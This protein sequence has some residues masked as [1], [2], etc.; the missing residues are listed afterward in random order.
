MESPS[1]PGQFIRLTKDQLLKAQNDVR[2]T[3]VQALGGFVL[4][5]GAGVGAYLTSRQVRVAREGQITERFTRAIDQ[6]GSE[7]LD[8]R[9]GG[10][11]ALERIARGSKD[12]HGP[13]IE[14]LTTYLREHSPWP[15]SRPGQY[16]AMASIEDIPSL[17]QRAADLQAV[18][19]VIGRRERGHE[20]AGSPP[21][22]AFID[23]RNAVLSGADLQRVDLR[24]AVVRGADL[25]RADLT[26]ADL[27]GVDLTG[28]DLTGAGLRLADLTGANLSGV[29]LTGVDLTGAI[30][31]GVDLTGADL[32]A[33]DLTS[34]DLSSA[35]LSKAK[36]W[37]QAQLDSARSLDGAT[38]PDLTADQ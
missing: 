16:V 38:L 5:L 33:A 36:Y 11:Y 27:T 35:D 28:A 8:V 34:A 29:F 19:T 10:I 4:L 9:L 32:T 1:N 20:D 13:I 15:P 30:L 24:G 3:G 2:T 18:L 25:T 14:I 37:N 26:R 17:A 22:L 6:L 21:T 31:T 7:K 12:D 23:L